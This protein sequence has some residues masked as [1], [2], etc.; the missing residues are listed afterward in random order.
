M[1]RKR[2]TR[3]VSYVR[4]NG[5]IYQIASVCCS[6][7]KGIKETEQELYVNQCKSTYELPDNIKRKRDMKCKRK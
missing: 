4:Q 7:K 6:E 1:P 2:L 3:H 5:K